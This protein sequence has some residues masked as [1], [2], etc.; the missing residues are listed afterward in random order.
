MNTPRAPR[1]AR[2]TA[3]VRSS[4]CCARWSLAASAAASSTVACKSGPACFARTCASTCRSGGGPNSS[5]AIRPGGCGFGRCGRVRGRAGRMERRT[6]SRSPRRERAGRGRE[7]RRRLVGR[8]GAQQRMLA[9]PGRSHVRAGTSLR[10]GAAASGVRDMPG[11][12]PSSWSWSASRMLASARRTCRIS[13]SSA[14][15]S[16]STTRALADRSASRGTLRPG[17]RSGRSRSRARRPDR[18]LT[19]PAHQASAPCSGSASSRSSRPFLLEQAAGHQ[20]EGDGKLR[21]VDL[22]RGGA[23]GPGRAVAVQAG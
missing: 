11:M 10:S 20:G 23:N 16:S 2:S 21:L 18:P 4:S 3:I 14:S 13:S 15:R 9:G 17:P 6:S 5:R 22:G 12:T 1:R 19:A 8:V 7:R